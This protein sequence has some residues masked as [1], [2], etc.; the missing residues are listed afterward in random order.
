MVKSDDRDIKYAK[1]EVFTRCGCGYSV[2]AVNIKT[3]IVLVCATVTT[4]FG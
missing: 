3:H 1:S 4:R 2:P